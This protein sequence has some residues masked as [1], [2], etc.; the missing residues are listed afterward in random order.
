MLSSRQT[1][2]T[3]ILGVGDY[4]GDGGAD[5]VAAGSGGRVW[6]YAG[7]GDGTLWPGRQPMTGGLGT[8]QYLG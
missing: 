3:Q 1:D 5:I 4:N 6:L 2:L 7:R 8:G